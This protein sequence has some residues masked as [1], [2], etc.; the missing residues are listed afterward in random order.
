MQP[1]NSSSPMLTL[2]QRLALLWVRKRQPT[3]FG[4]TKDPKAPRHETM[5]DL[6]RA[7]LVQMNPNRRPYD[8][9]RFCVSPLGVEVLGLSE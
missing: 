3:D 8:S 7:G 2:D 6:I 4:S 1:T 9:P 5:R